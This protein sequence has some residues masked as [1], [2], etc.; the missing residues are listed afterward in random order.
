MDEGDTTF[1]SDDDV[2]A[3]GHHRFIAARVLAHPDP[4]R[5]GELAPLFDASDVRGQISISRSTP[6]LRTPAGTRT[7]PLS[8]R[9]ITR[10]P[11]E[12]ERRGDE[13][14]VRYAFPSP[15]VEV[16]GQLLTG[17]RSFASDAI[18][19]G[20]VILFG[21][22][23]LWIGWAE[24]IDPAPAVEGLIGEST[25]MRR[26][27]QQIHRI[28]EV[29]VP[30]LLR[31]ETGAGKELVAAAIHKYSR[32]A[33]APY[34]AVNV[35][36]VPASM[37]ASELFG[38]RRGAF[39][40]AINDHKG[41][42]AQADGGTLF[43]DE[44][45]DTATEV[46]ALL[47]RVVQEGEIQP[48]G[49]NTRSVDVRLIAAT[50]SDLEAAVAERKFREPLW[51]RFSYEIH[52]PALRTR[53][54]DVGLLFMHLVQARLAE[55]G[56]GDRVDATRGHDGAFIPARLIAELARCRWPG[57]VR[58]LA[59]VALKFAL[60]NRGL[61]R[62]HVSSELLRMLRSGPAA[63]APAPAG[64]P[65]PPRKSADLHDTELLAAYRAERFST[66][67]TARRLGI[68]KSYLNKR[69]AESPGVRRARDL[70]REEIRTALAATRGSVPE[71]A[72]QLQISERALRLQLRRLSVGSD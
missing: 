32:R 62:A 63:P 30:V 55:M 5:I 4:T 64:A 52:V 50:D 34:V 8:S 48:V 12:L 59:N 33:G 58:E 45:G 31:G 69:L 40:G 72:A 37:A 10:N 56:D 44:I 24:L 38:H 1:S 46:Q 67:R 7:G 13:L 29:D 71:A 60:D 27:R 39:T 25:S 49:G 47:L 11:L 16:N 54:D 20:L 68:S 42:F 17:E 19:D 66:E 57:N 18:R 70:P 53:L 14:V 22:L 21:D 28:A 2:A 3:A 23:A 9:R 51:R 43:L 35:A 15:A 6:E 65:P 36:G 61:A 41:Y 26:L